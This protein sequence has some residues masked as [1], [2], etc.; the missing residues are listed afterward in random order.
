MSEVNEKKARKAAAA[1]EQA[2]KNKAF[3]RNAIIITV[4]VILVAACAFVINS[5]IFYTHTTAVEIGDTKY[6]PAEYNF[7]Y[8]NLYSNTYD[9]LSQQYGELMPYILDTEKP[10]SEQIC[11]YGDG[12]QTWHDYFHAQA[13]SEMLNVT[14]LYDAAVKAGK[15][16]SD[17]DKANIDSTMATYEVSAPMYGYSSVDAFVAANYG[18]GVDAELFREILEIQALASSYAIE[19][20]D[21]FSYSADELESYYSENKDR[22][23]FITYHAYMV[24]T[25]DAAFAELAEEDRAAAAAEAAAQIATATTPEEFAQNVVE[26]VAEDMKAAYED[27]DSTKSIAQG[28]NLSADVSEW[29]LDA[30]RVE[31]DTTVID[32]EGG[33]YAIMFVSRN[34]NHYNAVNARHILINAEAAEN[35]EYTDEALAAAK[36]KAEK[37]GRDLLAKVGLSEEYFAE[38]AN[39]YSEDGGSNTNGG[40]YEY[41][42]K[43]QMVEEFDA[44]LYE[45]HRLPGD[46]AIVYGSNG[47]Y[48]G[49]HVMYYVGEAGLYSDYLAESEMR[50]E[51][52]DEA[53]SA[54]AE[55][56]E[57]SEGFG[58]K[59]VG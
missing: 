7:Y 59:F 49:Y 20:N 55:S 8:N 41:I 21:S 11:L 10:L 44:F 36:E 28:A 15:T 27:V 1:A 48:A 34:D 19:L 26:F 51:D 57:T 46:T 54:L 38:L 50:A 2:K 23:D 3:K 4:V 45:E 39:T 22:F 16:L 58:M 47:Y 56:Y 35:G 5:D 17:E 40:L 9:S 53:V 25:S 12:T 32:T 29:M 18:K 13:V 14:V 6:S 30:A 33:S 24:S 52:Y 37:I 31:G 43:N 42:F